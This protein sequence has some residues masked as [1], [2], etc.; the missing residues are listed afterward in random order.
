MNRI[1]IALGVLVALPAIDGIA[2]KTEGADKY[3][4]YYAARHALERGDCDAGAFHLEAYLRN[5]SYIQE[6]Y[7]DHYREIRFAMEQC[8]SGVNVRGVEDESSEVDPIPDHPP[9]VD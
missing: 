1:S 9:M 2:G 8:K 6:R 3:P 7:P 4:D 5:H